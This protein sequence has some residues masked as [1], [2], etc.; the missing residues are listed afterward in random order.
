MSLPRAKT[1]FTAEDYLAWEERSPNQ[2]EYLA[3]E[4]GFRRDEPD[5]WVLQAYGPGEMAELSSLDFSTTIGA[6]YEDAALPVGED[7][8]WRI[9]QQETD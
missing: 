2:H 7:D 3:G 1:V 5:R 9:S 8:E 4:I 6:L